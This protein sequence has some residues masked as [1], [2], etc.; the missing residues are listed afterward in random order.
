[1]TDPDLAAE[2]IAIDHELADVALGFRFVLDLKPTNIVSAQALFE[3][4]GGVPVFEYRPLEDDPSVIGARLDAVAI[5]SVRDHTV[6]HLLLAKERELRLQVDMLKCRGSEDFLAL[7]IELYGAVSPALLAEATFLL[8][9]TPEEPHGAGAWL[10]ADAFAAKARTELDHYRSDHP[11]LEAHVEI[12]GHHWLDG[13]QRRTADRA[14]PSRGRAQ[15]RR[16]AA[17]RDRHPSGHAPQR[18]RSALHVLAAGLAGYEETRRASR[19]APAN[20]PSPGDRKGWVCAAGCV[21]TA[22]WPHQA[23]PPETQTGT[24][25]STPSRSDPSRA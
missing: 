13:V 1:M 2:D 12:R 20:A 16:A 24:R 11:D 23:G 3:R 15:G 17:A 18:C 9:H 10:D 22:T 5:D 19:C 8:D 25:R 6:A 4:D 21:T 14:D 7:S